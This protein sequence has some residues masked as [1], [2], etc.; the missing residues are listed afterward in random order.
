LYAALTASVVTA[1]VAFSTEAY[2]A[3]VLNS[4]P[5]PLAYAP[6]PVMAPPTFAG[7][8]IGGTL[9]GATASFDFSQTN[10]AIDASGVLGG[11]TGGYN[12]QGGP[13][14]LGF[15]GDALA[16]G[17]SGS[18]RFGGGGVNVAKPDMD[19]M[20]N[21]RARV[22]VTVTPQVLIF[23]TAGGAWANFD[24]PVTGPGGASRSGSSWGWSVG[25]GA[26]VAFNPNWSA[27]FDY[28]FTDFDPI[29][30]TYP[31]G[32]LKYD[33]DVNTYRGSLIYRF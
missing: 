6:P 23:A 2:S 4:G 30:E 20:L 25:G 10:D 24:L 31:G 19:A 5:P 29:R 13:I 17:I 8:W 28:Q 21:L 11:V 26:E 1:S 15:E 12:W 22:G 14:V 33:P 27:R 7:W 16:A 18:Q 3:D 9:G 32:S